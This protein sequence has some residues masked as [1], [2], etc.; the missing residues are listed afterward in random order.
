MV[1][2]ASMVDDKILI[3][4][5]DVVEIGVVV[6]RVEGITISVDVDASVVCFVV[7]VVFVDILFLPRIVQSSINEPERKTLKLV[8]MKYSVKKALTW[9]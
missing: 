7:N 5:V 9:P 2:M 1:V 3:V 6:M 4:L 8:E